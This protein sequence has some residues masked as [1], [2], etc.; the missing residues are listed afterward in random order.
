MPDDYRNGTLTVFGFHG[1]VAAPLGVPDFCFVDLTTFRA[2]LEA[3]ARTFEVVRLQDWLL[4]AGGGGVGGVGGGRAGGRMAAI[5]FD[6]GLRSVHD[7]AWPLLAEMG[8]PAWCFLPTNAIASGQ[9]LWWCRVHQ[10]ITATTHADLRWRGQD[11]DLAGREA[12]ASASAGLQRELSQL[13]AAAVDDELTELARALDVDPDATL[14]QD[15]PYR[16][17]DTDA[18]SALVKSGLIDMGGHSRSHVILSLL[19]PAE[20][21]DEVAGSVQIVRELT[22]QPADVFA[23]PNGQPADFDPDTVAAVTVSGIRAALTTVDGVCTPDSDPLAL[24]RVLLGS[25]WWANRVV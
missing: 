20:Q 12:R 15:S 5:T 25:Q 16:P 22:G 11:W 1:I 4:A 21:V 23:Y 13:T 2:Q 17:L 7:L 10:A 6:D 24:P 19:P 8:L 18:L 3:I 14:D 9:P